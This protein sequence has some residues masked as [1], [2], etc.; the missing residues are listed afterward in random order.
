[1]PSSEAL[2]PF[3]QVVRE[4]GPRVLAICRARVDAADVDDAWSETFLAALRAWPD[5]PGD[6]DVRAWLATVAARKCIDVHR[7]R[8]RR[9]AEP[10]ADVPDVGFEETTDDEGVWRHVAELPTKQRHVITYRY[11]GGLPYA[12]IVELVGGSEPAARRAAADGL[13]TLRD[14]EIR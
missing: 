7:A 6:L 10:V 13:R 11:L 2:P 1:M 14:K 8:Q 9:R 4:H 3:E 5:L 12:R